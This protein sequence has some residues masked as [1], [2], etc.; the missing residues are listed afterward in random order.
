MRPFVENEQPGGGGR[1][2]QTPRNLSQKPEGSGQRR[3]IGPDFQSESPAA[4]TAITTMPISPPGNNVRL[5][6]ARRVERFS[7][8]STSDD[9]DSGKTGECQQLLRHQQRWSTAPTSGDQPDI[10][11]Q[12][13]GRQPHKERAA[14]TTVRRSVHV[15]PRQ[16][17]MPIASTTWSRT[18]CLRHAGQESNRLSRFIRRAATPYP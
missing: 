13:Q 16:R 6:V 10:M 1:S 7:R 18:Q 17:V 14:P 12:K 2:F 5:N 8:P 4:R 11:H 15:A 3:G 9:A